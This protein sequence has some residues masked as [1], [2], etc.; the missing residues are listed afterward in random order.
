MQ[1]GLLTTYAGA[2]ALLGAVL[3]P[4]GTFPQIGPKAV[5]G[6]V[7]C[8]VG[9][10]GSHTLAAAP[11]GYNA[12]IRPLLSDRC[13]RCH[14]PDSAS[15]EA[16]LRLDRRDDTVALRDGRAA[17]VPRDPEASV[18]VARIMSDDPDLQM[19]PPDS[20]STL[21]A[22]ERD[23]I[24]QWIA[25]G[26]EYEPHWA[27]VPPVAA[28][29]PDV[30][31]E[32]LIRHP[33]DRF[34]QA[35]LEALGISAESEAD[36]ATLCRRLHLDIVGLP[37]TPAE[38]DA[39]VAAYAQA[40]AGA[41]REQV[42]LD[43]V[44]R[45]LASPR[46]GERMAGPWLDAARYA[47][48][49]GYQTDGPRQMWRYR[50]WVIDAF[51]R[52]QPFDEFTIHQLAGDLLPEPTRAQRIATAFNR[53]HRTNAEGGVI[54]AEFLV[55]YVVDRVETTATVWLA[56]TAGCA[57]CHDH[58][59]DPISQRDF[60]RL[61]DFFNRVPEPGRGLRDA[62]SPPRIAAPTPTQEARL[63]E[64]VATAATATKT[65]HELRP[66]IDRAEKGWLASPAA[67]D[68]TDDNVAAV[69]GRTLRLPL[70]HGAAGDGRNP[71]AGPHG[72]ATA[73]AGTHPLAVADVPTFDTERPFTAA[74]WLRPD[75]QDGT[76]TVWASWDAAA[77]DQGLHFA[78]ADRRPQLTISNRVLDDA[79]R[80]EAIEPLAAE[81]WSHVA[82]TYDGSRL[83]AGV[84]MHIDGRP[85]A[86]RV[87]KDE[88][89]NQFICKQPLTVAGGGPG[90]AYRGGIADLQLFDRDLDPDETAIVSCSLPARE[91]VRRWQ[92][93]TADAAARAKLREV[94]FAQAAAAPIRQTREAFLASRRAVAAFEKSIPTVMV[95]EDVP[96]LRKT[97]VLRRGEYDKPGEEVTAGVPDAFGLPL[98]ANAP[99]DR[100]ALARW[101]V[102]RRHPLT[103]RVIVNRVWHQCFGVGLVKTVEDFGVQ[104]EPPSHPELL[105]WLAVDFMDHGW[106]MK[107]LLRGI[108]T[109]AAY[110]RASRTT[111]EMQSRDPE[112][113]LFARG[114]RF[115]LPAEAVRDAA[116]A[117][118]GLLVERIGGP[119]VKPYQPAGLW[120]ELAA[121][122]TTYEQDH[123]PDLYRRSLYVYRKRTVAVPMFATFDAAARETCQVKQ[124]R[125]NTPLQALV[126]LN[127]VAFVEA[128]RGVAA[129]MIR[130]GGDTPAA[131]IAYGFKL[132]TA[133]APQ[134]PELDLLMA[135]FT[136]RHAAFHA[137]PAAAQ[138][139]LA[140]GESPV[141]DTID[142]VEL[143]AYATVGNVLLNL[144]EFLTRE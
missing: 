43:L 6:V 105:D 22:E 110:R 58:K 37:P 8:I 44:D 27:F 111:H 51:N 101:L 135:G 136:R 124:S 26:A 34:I 77:L 81:R 54:P 90:A 142:P 64:L 39:F 28:K 89:N 134:P 74:V 123:G 13:F 65:W 92:A 52:N 49:N 20:G 46:Y 41:A 30:R 117:V 115:R 119:S 139:L 102:D 125:T 23:L 32:P 48:T 71:V 91:L 4:Q 93:G 122:G 126:L 57:R 53:N 1:S 75:G 21:T 114:P 72:T 121:G 109:T 15:R 127:D 60:F 128:A 40:A 113:R 107:R 116:L 35:R 138:A 79:L 131:R 140:A 99:A 95:M 94:F 24:R 83:A 29:P 85:V 104:G 42:Y 106:D 10:A 18:V 108:V 144:D 96:G 3:N 7:A 69:T 143:A 47:D 66:D 59:Y 132:M 70:D 87:L 82:W 14:G 80:V 31:D 100:L 112:N 63:A 38:V 36:P 86:T 5:A 25:A 33:A 137:D 129:R 12:A 17:I 120:E 56:L 84:R 16:D 2:A 9:I 19:P 76:A 55:E 97:H 73:F 50:D 88:L 62:N 98:S 61:F 133:R 130:E 118:S 45:I 67:A 68:M 103:A 11:P 141:P 78:L